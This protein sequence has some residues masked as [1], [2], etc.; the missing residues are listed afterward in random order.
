MSLE[1]RAARDSSPVAG[2]RPDAARLK[3][4]QNGERR[5]DAF[6]ATCA[7]SEKRRH[8]RDL[9]RKLQK[10]YVARAALRNNVR[11]GTDL[12]FNPMPRRALSTVVE[13]ARI[14]ASR[15][16]PEAELLE[17]FLTTG[18]EAAFAVLVRRHRSMVLAACRQVLADDADVEDATQQTFLALWRNARSIRKRQSVGSWLFGVAHRLAVKELTLALRRRKVEGRAGKALSKSADAPDISWREACAI[19]HDELDRLP[20]KHRLPLLLCYLDGKSR[21]E[22]AKELG[23]PVGSLRGHLERGRTRLR[24]RLARRGVTLSAGLLAAVAG[25]QATAGP[26]LPTAVFLQAVMEQAPSHAGGLWNL[27]HTSRNVRRLVVLA[28]LAVGAAGGGIR[29]ALL[30]HQ[31]PPATARQQAPAA[32]EKPQAAEGQVTVSGRVLDPDGKPVA[33]ARLYSIDL[34]SAQVMFDDDLQTTARGTTG[35]DGRFRFDVAEPPIRS[36]TNRDPR[37]VI[38]AAEGYG[39]GWVARAAHDQELT[40]RLVKDLPISGR[41]LDGEGRPVANA[42]VSV[43]ALLTS[44]SVNLDRFLAQ[45][46]TDWRG[47]YSVHLDYSVIGPAPALGVTAT[48]ANGRF[49][50]TGCGVERV[51]FVVIRGPTIAQSV[52]R[53]VN[54]TGFEASSYNRERPNDRD[55]LYAPTFEFVAA[56]GKQISG[57]IRAT[58]GTPAVGARVVAFLPGNVS[59]ATTDNA[60]RYVL[61]GRPKQSEYSLTIQPAESTA[62]L[63]RAVKVP[64]TP[65]LEPLTADVT[66]AR[67]VFVTGR[68][69]DKQTGKGVLSNVGLAPLPGNPNLNKPGFEPG[70]VGRGV[71]TDRDGRFRIPIIPGPGVLMAQAEKGELLDGEFLNPYVPAAFDAQDRLRV[72]V[73]GVGRHATFASASGPPINLV[74]FHAVKYLDVSENADTANIDLYLDR[75]KTARLTIQDPDGNPLPGAIVSG[76]TEFGL[77]MGV[78]FEI[79]AAE[80]NLYALDPATPRTLAI[81]HRGRNLGGELT[82]RGDEIAPVVARLKPAG[83]VTGQYLDADARPLAGAGFEIRFLSPYMQSL[84]VRLRRDRPPL[85]T[86][87]DGRFRLEGVVPETKFALSGIRVGRTILRAR[88]AGGIKEVR[89]GETLDLGDL[90]AEPRPP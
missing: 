47:A 54:R 42:Q 89:P 24:A 9:S 86:D 4:S 15:T 17:Q 48:D 46:T 58:D 88:E 22:A 6:Q 66:L 10:S 21:D 7:P 73:D 83:A 16:V 50:I 36:D 44:S 1:W 20:H 72:Q 77:A 82:V 63:G 27:A 60:G 56:P 29:L 69:I 33:G 90:R 78:V 13:H 19:L 3:Y 41:V 51:A 87:K 85:M 84:E 68:V 59:V 12:R 76:V 64:D 37:R 49:R 53:V 81:Y 45:W 11:S 52:L 32:V 74:R 67:G 23:W 5:S 31:D 71:F 80:C 39:V 30:N 8:M 38:A 2:G 35:P 26:A 79:K 61:P 57:V 43:R 25:R 28:V 62:L 65:G 70:P 40:I 34:K 14:A 75:G 18:D 55:L